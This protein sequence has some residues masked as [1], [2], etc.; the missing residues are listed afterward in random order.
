MGGRGGMGARRPNGDDIAKRIEDM[1]SL[2]P[3]LKGIKLD[4]ARKDST[5]AIEKSYKQR[6]EDLGRAAKEM[7]ANDQ[8]PDPDS[9]RAVR[10][11]ARQMRDEE[12]ALARAVIDES[13]QAKFD[14]NVQKIHDDEAKREDEMRSRRGGMGGMEPPAER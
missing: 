4:G 6:F 9:L 14:A 8:R 13:Q 1:A 2:K 3:A 5:K 11:D 7:F 12:L 10:Q